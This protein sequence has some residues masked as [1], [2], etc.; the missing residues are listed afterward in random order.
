ML[1]KY[2]VLNM[3]PESCINR[4]VIADGLPFFKHPFSRLIVNS[5]NL[6]K[7]HQIFS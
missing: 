1:L 6:V 7:T 4:P 2:L 3:M 5:H